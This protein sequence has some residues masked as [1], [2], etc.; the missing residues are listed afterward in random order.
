MVMHRNIVNPTIIL[1]HSNPVHPKF[2]ESRIS[3][4]KIERCLECGA[5]FKD[6]PLGYVCDFLVCKHK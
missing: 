4:T 3:Y 6:S 1:Y 5:S 2:E